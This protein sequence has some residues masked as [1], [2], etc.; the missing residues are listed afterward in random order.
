MAGL[1]QNY[2]YVV[3]NMVR[4]QWLKTLRLV[5][6]AKK[7]KMLFYQLAHTLVHTSAIN[8]ES[9]KCIQYLM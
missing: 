9:I 4:I 8:K 3:E 2:A 6:K 5:K 1:A 7:A